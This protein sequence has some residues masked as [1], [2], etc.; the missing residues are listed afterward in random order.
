[1][2]G[3]NHLSVETSPYLLQHKDN[4]VHWFA[5]HDD[6]WKKAVDEDKLVLVSIGYSACHWCHVME[7][8]VFEDFECAELMNQHFVC[9]KV[10]REE[11][12]DIDH[13]YM[14]AVHLMGGRGGWP[15]NVFT[16]PDGRPVYGGTYFPKL[17]WLNILENLFDVY[18]REKTKVLAYADRLTEGL[19]QLHDFSGEKKHVE[20]GLQFVEDKVKEW[21]SSWDLE[22]GGQRRAPKFPMPVTL[23][24]LLRYGYKHE[25]DACIAHVT[26]TLNRMALGGIYDQIG[27]GFCRYSVDALWKVPHFEKMLYDNAQL[28][29]VYA[30]AYSAGGQPLF[31]RIAEQT[32]AWAERELKTKD[33]LFCAALDADSEGV[34]G[35][36]Y[37]WTKSEFLLATGDDAAIATEY[38]RVGQEGFWE[39]GMNILL[40]HEQDESFAAKH[41]LS[42]TDFDDIRKRFCEKLLHERNKRIRPGLDDKVLTSWN[43][44]LVSAYVAAGD[45][46]RDKNYLKSAEELYGALK[47]HL[48]AE[49]VIYRAFTKGMRSIPG[50]LDDYAFLIQA[51]IDLYESTGKDLYLKEASH[52]TDVATQKFY[53]EHTGIFNYATESIMSVERSDTEDNVIPSS[54]SV[55]ARCLQKLSVHLDNRNDQEKSTRLMNQMLPRISHGS[56]YSNW[57]MLLLDHLA[58]SHEVVITGKNAELVLSELR[59]HYFPECR[60]AASTNESELPLFHARNSADTT[61]YVCTGRACHAPVHHVSEALALLQES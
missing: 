31:R 2:E 25:S 10:D 23:E 53:R 16:L 54:L 56:A 14:D 18:R 36:Y 30:H 57:L 1:M 47:R 8:E 37:C 12:P 3:K 43:A 39:H 46:F 34:E 60:F 61:I 13:I 44:M 15:L 24:F 38:F 20:S 28:I 48:C 33:G 29:S 49:D 55:M 51:A 5:W 40:C 59:A 45:A 32:I 22:L 4:P 9:I 21:M 52:W 42:A 7:H 26:Q 27:G 41:G 58:V 50:F 17:Q 19:T 6:A 35:K 11:R